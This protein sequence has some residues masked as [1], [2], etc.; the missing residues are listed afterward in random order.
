MA[1]ILANAMQYLINVG[2]PNKT[3]Q[4]HIEVLTKR[5]HTLTKKVG[6]KDNRAEYSLFSWLPRLG[7]LSTS[8]R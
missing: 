6:K 2:V 3:C 5:M 4:N 8:R 1:D 7:G